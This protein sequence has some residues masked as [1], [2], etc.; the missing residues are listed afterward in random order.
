[1]ANTNWT[2]QELIAYILLFVAHSDLK[3]TKQ[4][5]EY[6]LSRV[7]EETYMHIKSEFDADNDYQ[8]ITKIIDA[9]HSEESYKDNPD[10]LFA[11][12]KLMAFADGNMDQMEYAIYN[13]LKKILS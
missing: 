2:K 1:M 9:I 8:S 10:E 11:D 6:I 4:E 7:D 5:H 12:I 13:S 3:E